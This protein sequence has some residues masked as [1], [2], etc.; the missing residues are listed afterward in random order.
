MKNK[1]RNVREKAIPCSCFEKTA[2]ESGHSTLSALASL[3][4][5]LSAFPGCD[6]SSVIAGV[7]PSVQQHDG[8][9]SSRPLL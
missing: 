9:P 6:K 1:L 8:S 3:E 2:P 7:P 4:V 5:L